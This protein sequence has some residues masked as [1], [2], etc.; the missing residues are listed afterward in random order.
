MRVLPI[1]LIP[2]TIW[3][4]DILHLSSELVNSYEM[5][6]SNLGLLE[7]ARRG[8]DKKD[9]HGGCNREEA[10]EHFTYRFGVSAGRSEFTILAPS[11]AI[12]KF[13]D[14]L[15]S[16]FSDGHVGLLDIPCGTGSA[17]VTF[18][19]VLAELRTKQILPKLPLTI[20]IV[21][22]DCSKTALGICRSML[23]RV[24]PILAQQGIIIHYELDQWNATRNDETA[25]MVDK[26][27]AL[28][29]G[30][31][32]YVVCISNFSGALIK[33]KI[34]DDFTPCLS[35]I[36]G[37]LH[38]KRSTLIWIEPVDSNAKKGLIPKIFEFIN[39]SIPWFH[40]A[41]KTKD[42]PSASYQMKNPINE[43]VHRTGVQVQ[44][45]ERN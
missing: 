36:L 28:A 13:S 20:S 9:I 19:T 8:T 1:K 41:D 32:E 23:D 37:R 18:L 6:L 3:D 22:G 21:G 25:R 24:R 29:N 30:A 44:R 16:T 15:L 4:K 33:G 14:A 26:W 17:S 38:D 40:S 35:Q 11:E 12:T 45:F 2:K 34:F 42:F 43:H 7:R 31:G 27:F 10:I 39:R 5:E